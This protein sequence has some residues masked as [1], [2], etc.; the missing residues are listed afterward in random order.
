V[1]TSTTYKV[2]K[3]HGII[4]QVY[5]I[6]AKYKSKIYNMYSAKDTHELRG[7]P[8]A[9]RKSQEQKEQGLVSLL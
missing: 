8:R 3:E 1:S 6:T 4:L 2:I 7:I 5:Y 9:S